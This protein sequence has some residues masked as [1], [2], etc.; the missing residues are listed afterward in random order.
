MIIG[1]S[2]NDHRDLNEWSL[3]P[4]GLTIGASIF[5][6]PLEKRMFSKGNRRFR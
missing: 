3:G 5:Y 4:K 1:T 2:V 6:T